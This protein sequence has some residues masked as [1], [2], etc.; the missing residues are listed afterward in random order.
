MLVLTSFALLT[1]SL[2]LSQSQDIVREITFVAVEFCTRG[3]L[4]K[5][6]FQQLI[7]P[8]VHLF[9]ANKANT[10]PNPDINKLQAHVTTSYLKVRL[11]DVITKIACETYIGF[12]PH[13]FFSTAQ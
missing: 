6:I 2:S 12:E 3:A 4:L 10:V 5:V 7:N 9:H 8:T 11:S 13:C 1:R